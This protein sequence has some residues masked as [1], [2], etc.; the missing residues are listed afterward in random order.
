MERNPSFYLIGNTAGLAGGLLV[1]YPV[2]VRTQNHSILC[3]K[4]PHVWAIKVQLQRPYSSKEIL[5]IKSAFF[6]DST[7]ELSAIR[8]LARSVKFRKKSKVN[9]SGCTVSEANLRDSITPR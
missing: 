3:D 1:A 9:S 7:G 4:P 6:I 5:I 8:P 2:D